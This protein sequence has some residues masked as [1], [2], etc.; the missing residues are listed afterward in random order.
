ML[1]ASRVRASRNSTR[2]GTGRSRRASSS[3]ECR[4]G[5]G[6]VAS[7]ATTRVAGPH[8]QGSVASPRDACGRREGWVYGRGASDSRG[9]KNAFIREFF[10]A[11]GC[12][13]SG[14]RP[15]LVTSNR[16]LVPDGAL[17]T[18]QVLGPD[19]VGTANHSLRDLVVSAHPTRRNDYHFETVLPGIL[20]SGASWGGGDTT[21]GARTVPV[22]VAVR[23]AR[24]SAAQTGSA[25]PVTMV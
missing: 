24:A 10:R 19:P 16:I 6:L 22:A 25:P 23:T 1:L 2:A 21:T 9:G 20:P 8:P 13:T 5:P 18:V 14:S 3:R 11:L 4:Y 12:Q 7:A 17:T 15:R